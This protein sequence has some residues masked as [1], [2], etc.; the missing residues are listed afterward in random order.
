MMLSHLGRDDAAAA[1]MRAIEEVL[2]QP[3]LR[4]PDLGGAASTVQ[5]G[6]AIAAAV[7]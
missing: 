3:A 1:V 6:C 4:T 7:R 2:S 5:C